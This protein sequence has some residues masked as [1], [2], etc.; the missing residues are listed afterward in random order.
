MAGTSARCRVKIG[1]Y[2]LE[3]DRHG[4]G[5]PLPAGAA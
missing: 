5:G 3:R 4:H 1:A 2:E